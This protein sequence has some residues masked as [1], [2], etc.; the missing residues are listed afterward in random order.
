[1]QQQE[2]EEEKLAMEATSSTEGSG[3]EDD[4]GMDD[5]VEEHGWQVQRWQRRWQ[6]RWQGQW[7]FLQG[8]NTGSWEASL[9]ARQQLLTS[10]VALIAVGLL[11]CLGLLF[12]TLSSAH[13]AAAPSTGRTGVTGALG[14]A[15]RA[16]AGS[17][18]R[19]PGAETS[20]GLIAKLQEQVAALQGALRDD[21]KKGGLRR[22]QD[23]GLGLD[24]GEEQK[25][26]E[27]RGHALSP[28]EKLEEAMRPKPPAALALR[29]PRPGVSL[30]Q[31]RGQ[32]RGRAMTPA[33]EP[34]EAAGPDPG[35]LLPAGVRLEPVQV[36]SSG[37]EATSWSSGFW[38]GSLWCARGSVCCNGICGSPWSSCCADQ[39]IIC[40][41]G[42]TCCGDICCGPEAIC[43]NGVCGA[44]NAHCWNGVL[45]L[46]PDLLHPS[47]LGTSNITTDV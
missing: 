6:R 41:P 24:E 19:G 21:E 29:R 11:L 42:G 14:T 20:A 45:P 40:Q 43:C 33:G 22:A 39:K 31:E 25:K 8:T 18:G 12:F 47:G 15:P 26:P 28:R 3:G 27:S 5:Q 13:G 7:A 32:S 4:S 1:M 38:C 23:L 44:P 30:G 10:P 34:G 2:R 35:P 46:P 36:P 16:A 9:R 37:G 17:V